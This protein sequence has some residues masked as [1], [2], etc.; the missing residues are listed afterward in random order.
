MLY[1]IL[2]SIY[3]LY[4]CVFTYVCMSRCTYI[5]KY[6]HTYI[7]ENCEVAVTRPQSPWV[8]TK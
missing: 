7:K 1:Y 5:L 8:L 2:S 6:I 3:T 4:M